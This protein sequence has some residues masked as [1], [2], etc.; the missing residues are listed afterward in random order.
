MTSYDEMKKLFPALDAHERG[1]WNALRGS[2]PLGDQAKAAHNPRIRSLEKGGVLSDRSQ[3][4]SLAARSHSVIS[5]GI[6][7]AKKIPPRFDL[8]GLAG[9][10]RVYG[11]TGRG[12]LPYGA[13]PHTAADLREEERDRLGITPGEQA[14]LDVE[15]VHALEIADYGGSPSGSVVFHLAEWTEDDGALACPVPT[16]QPG[17]RPHPRRPAQSTPRHDVDAVPQRGPGGATGCGDG[18]DER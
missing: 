8:I 5:A 10:D 1:D 18:G 13:Y 17:T 7:R 16:R 6:D 15:Y 11:N 3:G 9:M 4:L 2:D 12:L 14:M